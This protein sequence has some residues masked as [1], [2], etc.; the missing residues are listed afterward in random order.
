MA[1]FRSAVFAGAYLQ[2]AGDDR[3]ACAAGQHGARCGCPNHGRVNIWVKIRIRTGC[4]SRRREFPGTACSAFRRLRVEDK[5][6]CCAVATLQSP[7]HLPA[8][9][10]AKNLTAGAIF[11]PLKQ[12]I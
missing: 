4:Q 3:G 11:I 9:K 2:R 6:L 1:F 10:I 12:K 5:S 8:G 7:P